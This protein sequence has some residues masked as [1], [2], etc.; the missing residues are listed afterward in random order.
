VHGDLFYERTYK[1]KIYTPQEHLIRLSQGE[2][3]EEV[4]NEGARQSGL[5]LFDGASGLVFAGIRLDKLWFLVYQ[6]GVWLM[7]S[8]DDELSDFGRQA[9]NRLGENWNLWEG[10]ELTATAVDPEVFAISELVMSARERLVD[11]ELEWGE[12]YSLITKAFFRLEEALIDLAAEVG[13]FVLEGQQV[14]I[15]DRAPPLEACERVIQIPARG[16]IRGVD[17]FEEALRG[18][19]RTYE[20]NALAESLRESGLVPV[21]CG[22]GHLILLADNSQVGGASEATSTGRM[23]TEEMYDALGDK[24]LTLEQAQRIVPCQCEACN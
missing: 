12:K 5:M 9:R 6:A 19:V 8:E 3:P 16:S 10:R 18:F 23:I 4:W 11:L 15:D 22:E 24:L 20:A 17:E 21:D 1:M 14:I 2:L 13:R 7:Q